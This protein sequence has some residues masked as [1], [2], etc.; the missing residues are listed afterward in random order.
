MTTLFE[1][2]EVVQPASVPDSKPGLTTEFTTGA[3]TVKVNV[4]DLV[5]VVPTART[6]IGYEPTAAPLLADRVSVV[7]VPEFTVV[8]PNVAVTPDGTLMAD[9]ASDWAL[10]TLLSDT[11]DATLPTPWVTAPEVGER[12]TPNELTV[13]V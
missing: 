13:S 9:R 6:V 5:S 12:V 3:F 8:E 11:V 7:L 1:R 10:P 4:A 2:P